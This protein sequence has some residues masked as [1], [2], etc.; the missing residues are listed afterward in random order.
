[1]AINHTTNPHRTH[2][3]T[4]AV[5]TT[6]AL[7][8]LA[9]AL[10]CGVAPPRMA[11][12][13]STAPFGGCRS[14]RSNMAMR[15]RNASAALDAIGESTFWFGRSLPS[16][17]KRSFWPCSDNMSRALQIRSPKAHPMSAL[18]PGD[19]E[20]LPA[21]MAR[22]L[23][24]HFDP[25][26]VVRMGTHGDGSCFFHSLASIVNYKGYLEKSSEDR[27]G[28][29]REFRCAFQGAM[30][31]KVWNDIVDTTPHNIKRPFHDVKRGFCMPHEWADESMIKYTSATTGLNIL[32]IDARTH[33][34]YCMVNGNESEQDSVVV[35]WIDREHF[36]PVLF[37][38]KR[39]EDHLHLHGI[40]DRHKAVSTVHHLVTAFANQC[41]VLSPRAV[42]DIR[43]RLASTEKG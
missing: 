16:A 39:C 19:M 35:L 26:N 14:V 7:T 2:T 18:E 33:D 31:P 36:E 13:M 8:F 27:L 38:R 22:R 9:W 25:K 34:F 41:A 28:L 40:L 17:Q 11:T 5:I 6:L 3:S 20:P 43:T 29:G 10:F 42:Q 23:F 4:A 30:S 37:V 15:A 21:E 32:F 12:G 1:M 24:P